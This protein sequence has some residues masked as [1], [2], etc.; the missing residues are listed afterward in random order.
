M[1]AVLLLTL[2]FGM[3]G[4]L[5]FLYFWKKGQFEDVEETKY[6]MFQEEE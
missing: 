1:L 6:Q 3:S 5:V 2:A 4:F